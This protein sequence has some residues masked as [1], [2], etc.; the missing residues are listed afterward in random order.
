MDDRSAL[1][2]WALANPHMVAID[3]DQQ[4]MSDGNHRACELR[5]E[6]AKPFYHVVNKCTGKRTCGIHFAGVY[7]DDFVAELRAIG[8]MQGNVPSRH[9]HLEL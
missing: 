8:I 4:L 1:V 3:S 5:H 2:E 7:N 6:D 9:T